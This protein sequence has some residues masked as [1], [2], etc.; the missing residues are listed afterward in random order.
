MIPSGPDVRFNIRAADVVEVLKQVGAAHGSPASIR[1][2]HGTEFVS[3]DLHLWALQRGITL[4]FSRPD[5]PTD[6]AFIES[7]NGKFRTECLN[8]HWFMRLPDAREK[9]KAWR[10]EYNELR[11]H[12]A[13]GN[14]TPISLVN[15]PPACSPR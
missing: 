9:V 4:D 14:K 10:R 11:S 2:D 5:K 1:V 7:F 15:R 6:N 3:R 13:I 12:S 8:A